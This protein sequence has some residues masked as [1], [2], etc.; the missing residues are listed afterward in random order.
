[1]T[2]QEYKIG[3]ETLILALQ[4]HRDNAVGSIVIIPN[5]HIT[6]SMLAVAQIIHRVFSSLPGDEA[7]FDP[8]DDWNDSAKE[9][10]MP[11]EL[12]RSVTG[13]P[14]WITPTSNRRVTV[15]RTEAQIDFGAGSRC[16][17]GDL[18]CL[19]MSAKIPFRAYSAGGQKSLLTGWQARD[20]IRESPEYVAPP[21]QTE[22]LTDDKIETT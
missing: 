12:Q 3:E 21:M 17:A 4:A 5:L 18:M 1:M 15:M 6:D 22:E 8:P 7:F 9:T 11:A 20:I 10:F 13:S 16:A 19:L 2:N 14:I